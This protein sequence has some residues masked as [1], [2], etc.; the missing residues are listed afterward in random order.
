MAAG[1]GGGDA[2]RDPAE[3]VGKDAVVL[4]E[5]PAFMRGKERFSAP[6]KVRFDD[7]L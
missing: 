7:A 2:G 1:S 5:A 6:G 4:V 3:E